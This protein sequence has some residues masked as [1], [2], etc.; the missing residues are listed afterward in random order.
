[1]TLSTLLV[2]LFNGLAGAS[3][4][5]LVAAGLSL[6]FGVTRIVNFAHGSLMMLGAYLAYT[7]IGRFGSGLAGYWGGVLFAAAAVGALGV[8]IERT[9]LRRLYGKPELLQLIA[10]FG[11]VL[12][13]KD[14]VLAVWG[15][16]DLLGPRAPGLAGA[17]TIFGQAVPQ[18]DLLLIVLA[19]VILAALSLLLARTR[20]GLLVRAATEDRDMTA[21]LGVNPSWLFSSVFFVGALLAGLAGAL[22]LPREPANLNMDLTVIAD[23]F[24]VTVVGGLGSIR[25]AF[26]AALI[27]GMIKALCIAIGD[28][29]L[30]GSVVSF[31]KLTLVAE[32]VVMAIVL[33]ARPWGLYGRPIAQPPLAEQ[34]ELQ[35]APGRRFAI[36]VTVLLAA[37]AAAP[38]FVD[39]YA[40]VLGADVLIFALFAVSLHFMMGP[41]GMASFGHAAYF[42]LGAYGAALAVRAVPMEVALIVA[43]LAAGIGALVF[44][45]FCVRLSGV[46]LAMLTLAFAQITWATA[47]QWDAVT[48][49][50]NGLVGVWPAAWLSPRPAY[51]WLTLTI[52]AVGIGLLWRAVFAPFGYALRAARDSPQR[53]AAIGIDVRTVRW[54]AFVLAGLGAGLAGALYAFSKGSISP[55]SLSIP[56]SVDGLVMVLLGGLQTLFGPVTGAVLFAW[57]QDTLARHTPYWRAL[58]GATILLLVLLFPHGI[59]GTVGAATRRLIERLARPRAVDA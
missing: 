52:S 31:A 15:P 34:R 48:G 45:W 59:V 6:I 55:E 9:L 18:Y 58:L 44:G 49:G 16:E 3:S 12:L 39:E 8:A 54:T 57:L 43:P 32:F 10:T 41:G 26:V 27:I 40:L 24:V 37:L 35:T 33:V 7:L 4:L 14:G 25:G 42:G 20:W 47:Y 50:S 23:V 19:P 51:Y 13:V 22:Q 53:A 11:V 36:A 2:Q 46:Y 29:P 17:V 38:L 21:A 30:L 56:R 1:M 28:I 5:F